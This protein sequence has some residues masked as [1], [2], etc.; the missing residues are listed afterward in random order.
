MPADLTALWAEVTA[1]M[2]LF[3][4]DLWIAFG[5]IIGGTAFLVARAKRAVR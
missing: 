3:S 4:A 5:G 1:A 2:A